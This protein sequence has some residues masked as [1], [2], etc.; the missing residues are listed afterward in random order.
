ARK[1]ARNGNSEF[2]YYGDTNNDGI[3]GINP[4]NNKE[5][6]RVELFKWVDTD[7]DGKLSVGYNQVTGIYTVEEAVTF[8]DDNNNGTFDFSYDPIDPTSTNTAVFEGADDDAVWVINPSTV[9]QDPVFT[10]VE[11]GFIDYNDDSIYNDADYAS[12]GQQVRANNP[13][14][15]G[16]EP[17][18]GGLVPDFI[19]NREDIR[20]LFK[21]I[22][23]SN[24]GT[25]FGPDSYS[26]KSFNYV[27][28]DIDHTFSDNFSMKAAFAFEDLQD[29]QLSS[30]WSA[31]QINFSSGYGITVRYP[32]L[33]SINSYNNNPNNTGPSPFEA[34]LVDLTNANYAHKVLDNINSV[35]IESIRTALKTA[36]EEDWSGTINNI[37]FIAPNDESGNALIDDV[38]EMIDYFVDEFLDIS[39]ANTTFEKY[40]E[41]GKFSGRVR[42]FLVRSERIDLPEGPDNWQYTWGIAPKSGGRS[43][44]DILFDV[45]TSSTD[46]I[47]APTSAAADQLFNLDRYIDVPTYR[48]ELQNFSNANL[49][50]DDNYKDLTDS[51][52]NWINAFNEKLVN[53]L[54]PDIVQTLIDQNIASPLIDYLPYYIPAE[55]FTLNETGERLIYDAIPD[56]LIKGFPDKGK[57]REMIALPYVEIANTN[58]DNDGIDGFIDVTDLDEVELQKRALAKKIY[59]VLVEN[60]SDPN[61]DNEFWEAT[62]S[63]YKIFKEELHP[64]SDYS[65][66]WEGTIQQNL[67]TTLDAIVEDE[68]YLSDNSQFIDTDDDGVRDILPSLVKSNVEILQPFIRRQW[69]KSKNKDMNRSARITFNYNEE[70]KRIPGKQQFL[71]GIDLDNRDA[72]KT[73]E[74]QVSY[75]VR[76][77]G[78]ANNLYLRNDILS[79]YI[80]LDDIIYDNELDANFDY[81]ISGHQ[82][83]PVANWLSNGRIPLDENNIAQMVTTYHAVTKVKSNALWA[84]ASG[85]YFN[86]KLRT[87]FGIRRDNIKTES[88]YSRFTLRSA[89]PEIDEDGNITEVSLENEIQDFNNVIYSPSLGGLYWI[90]KNLAVFGNYSESVISPNG[91]QFDVFGKLTPPETGKGKEIG[92]KLSTQD[93]VLNGQLT[94]FS[95]DKKNEQRQNISWPMLASIY[96][97]FNLDGTR[98]YDPYDNGELPTVIWDYD[99]YRSR[100]GEYLRDSQ[101]RILTRATFEPKGYRVADE[102]VRSEGIELDLYYNPTS[103]ISIFLGYAYLETLVLES[104]L[105]TLEG[106]PTA[107]TSDHN[108]NFTAKYSIKEGK[109]KGLQFG[110]NQKYRSAAL[111]SHYF[112]DLDGDNQADYFSRDVTDPRSNEPITLEPRYNTLWLEDQHRTDFFIKWSG[113]IKKT[114]PWT[115]LQMNINN[116]FDNKDLISTGLNNARYT[117]GRNVVLSAGIYF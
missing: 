64:E 42:D 1:Y 31:N 94:F 68:D 62:N 30:G 52:Y 87:L 58:E 26:R 36:Y 43:L 65:F 88:E 33:R 25:G 95:I 35:G 8:I 114:L 60:P 50:N 14:I 53:P 19:D 115:V 67:L 69:K 54:L 76:T 83:D 47:G 78:D 28:G 45:L 48:S 12:G 108:V 97:A 82:Y 17:A 112:V 109:Y 104:A 101:G 24:S 113:K 9:G 34:V 91:F 56:W 27:I 102:S 75:N 59:K 110:M 20:D 55:E 41:L 100:D 61:S 15:W 4:E 105:E 49:L 21:G 70:S 7:G 3:T 103:N 46:E 74:Q 107:G 66:M 23:Y 29:D 116:V 89:N 11:E 40:Y 73:D 98:R 38:D 81:N 51:N 106:L 96:P 99:P 2:I 63:V 10:L 6:E 22:D 13:N 71:F 57:P 111:L 79:D 32:T 117:D 84:A 16:T 39:E 44:G 93:N 72:S 37:N 86:G 80:V 77:W 85:S 92:F 5:D 90:T 18:G